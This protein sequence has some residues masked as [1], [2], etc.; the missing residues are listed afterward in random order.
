[1]WLSL[2]TKSTWLALDNKSNN[3]SLFFYGCLTQG[4]PE[5]PISTHLLSIDIFC[6]YSIQLYA[7]VSDFFPALLHFKLL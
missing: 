7:Y 5:Q 2:G 6:L 1:M 3:K 4:L